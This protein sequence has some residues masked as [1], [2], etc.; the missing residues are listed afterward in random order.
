MKIIRYYIALFIFLLPA[1]ASGQ[2]YNQIDESGNITQRDGRNGNFNPHSNDT[3]KAKEVPKG[4]YTWTVDRRFGDMHKV[5]VDTLPH[6]YPQ[7]TMA[8]GMYG[9]YNTIGS[10]YTS[11][12]SRIFADR[13]ESS[14]F[15]FLDT[16]D[17]ML[18]Q[19]DQWHFTNTLSPITNLS[20]G[21]CGDKTNGEDLINALFA[22]NAGKRTGI[23]FNLD[24]RYARGYYQNQN[25][26]HFGATFF[27]SHLGDR[28]Q[29]HLLYQNWHQK[30][31]EN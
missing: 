23:G 30:A 25:N 28:Y 5:D 9:D 1:F 19:P 27:V 16:Y 11:R 8:T 20:Y 14:Q 26:S 13:K 22:V 4:I 31:A 24:Y 6:L 21:S 12:L 10:N 3:T 15:L 18:R 2:T 17:Q 29:L 7:S